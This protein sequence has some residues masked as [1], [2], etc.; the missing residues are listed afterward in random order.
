MKGTCISVFLCLLCLTFS[1]LPATGQQPDTLSLNEYLRQVVQHHPT[2]RAAALLVEQGRMEVRSARGFFDPVLAAD[3]DEK[4]FKDKTY[5]RIFGSELKATTR[6]GIGLKAGYDYAEGDYLNPERTVPSGGLWYAGVSVPLIQGLIF[7]EGRGMLRQAR[8]RQERYQWEQQQLLA[9]L[10]YEA[11]AAYWQWAGNY[12]QLSTLQNAVTVAQQRFRMVRS[13]FMV[14]ELPAID[15]LEAF[16]QLQT[17]QSSLLEQ[18]QDLV[19]S[20]Q[21]AASFFWSEGGDPLWVSSSLPAPLPAPVLAD[22]LNGNSDPEQLIWA[23]ASPSVRLYG[24][25]IAELEAERRW[26]AEKLKPYLAAS[27]NILSSE[28]PTE[29]P[30]SYSPNNYKIGVS[31]K[32]PLLLRS[33]RGELQLNRLKMQTAALEQ[34]QKRLEVTN[35]LEALISSL[36]LLQD[37]IRLNQQ[38][39]TGYQAMW[40]GE[41]RKF[42]YG[43]ST[44]FYV[45]TRE[46]KY[47]ESRL[48]LL[49]LQVKF[50]QQE[51]EL[52]R[53]MGI[54]P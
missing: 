25:K 28:A 39:V 49:S 32:M 6:L 48:K 54:V 22:S 37:Q 4:Q 20:E 36:Q 50:Q 27:Y 24:Y 33:A 47:L 44:L 15:T 1:A 29:N 13:G 51:A 31:F 21:A 16:L 46:L 12:Q 30:A 42:E 18:E 35:K 23:E 26:K 40:L 34:R 2:A 10:L 19:K 3:L 11:T 17:L 45:N 53:L 8:I 9:N 41:Q 43:E 14:G 52:R 38:L 7:D 5:Y